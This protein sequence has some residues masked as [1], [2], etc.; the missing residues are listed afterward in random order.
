MKKVWFLG[1]PLQGQSALVGNPNDPYV[2]GEAIYLHAI[3]V[4]DV[5]I[6]CAPE[7]CD[8]GEKVSEFDKEYAKIID[9]IKKNT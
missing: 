3:S 1:G 5:C 4:G 7:F 9:A 6:M 8:G 2:R